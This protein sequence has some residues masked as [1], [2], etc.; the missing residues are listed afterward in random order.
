MKKKKSD[1]KSLLEQATK[2]G[3]FQGKVEEVSSFDLQSHFPSF[4]EPEKTTNNGLYSANT[5]REL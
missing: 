4:V 3:L 2:Y 5:T 1:L